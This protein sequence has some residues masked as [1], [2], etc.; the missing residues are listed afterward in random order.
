MT[1]SLH[2]PAATADA[3]DPTDM[4]VKGGGLPGIAKGIAKDSNAAPLTNGPGRYS[5]GSS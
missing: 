4:K 1:G 5:E 2:T 3:R